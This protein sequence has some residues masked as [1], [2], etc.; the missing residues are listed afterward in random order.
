MSAP[1]TCGPHLKTG[2]G[3]IDDDHQKL[4]DMLGR[5]GIAVSEGRNRIILAFL[6]DDLAKFTLKHFNHE[7]TLMRQF[8][9]ADSTRH[10]EEHN[11]LIAE[12]IAFKKDL[13][14]GKV[15]IT[16]ELP[17]FLHDWLYTHILE[18]DKKLGEALGAMGVK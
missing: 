3:I 2:I 11:K 1:T 6:L 8:K 13:E 5:L 12:L 7:E 10:I 4:L 16:A 9:Y 14:N 17:A 15:M 18:S